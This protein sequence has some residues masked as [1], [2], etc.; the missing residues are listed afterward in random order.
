VPDSNGCFDGAEFWVEF[1][2]TAEWT[3]PLRP[4]QVGWIFRRA[5]EGG[6]VFVA[7]RR[8]C[9]AGP[10]RPAAD[11]LWIHH[12]IHARELKA[13]GLRAV[14]PLMHATGG[15]RAWSWDEV[16]RVLARGVP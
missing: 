10:R 6:R 9:E 11:E 15:P 16:L 4:E 7:T 1:K 2:R 8:H 3:C 12:G 13:G 5:R 14:P